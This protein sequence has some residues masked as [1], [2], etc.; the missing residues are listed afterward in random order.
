MNFAKKNDRPRM[1]EILENYGGKLALEKNNHSKSKG[2]SQA[3]KQQQPKKVENER[4]EKKPYVLTVLKN[5]LW[6]PIT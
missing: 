2:K 6:E 1:L 3:T 5:G 4:L